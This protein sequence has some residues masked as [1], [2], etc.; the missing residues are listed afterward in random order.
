MINRIV[1][2]P[3]KKGC[4][5]G[6]FPQSSDAPFNRDSVSCMQQTFKGVSV[7]LYLSKRQPT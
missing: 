2:N 4:K 5:G 1:G 3:K 6:G 7:G